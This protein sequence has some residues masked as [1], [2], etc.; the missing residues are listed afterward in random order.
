MRQ[1][2]ENWISNA[3]TL[4]AESL[5]KKVNNM[6]DKE[7][8]FSCSQR[9]FSAHLKMSLRKARREAGNEFVQAYRTYRLRSGS[10]RFA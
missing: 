3:A 7:L 2:N 4:N 6:T 9:N 1:T 5:F 8:L 10:S